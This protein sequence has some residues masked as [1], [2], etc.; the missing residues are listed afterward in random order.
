MS[1]FTSA[2][3]EVRNIGRTD[4]ECDL[5]SWK[6]GNHRLRNGYVGIRKIDTQNGQSFKV[7]CEIFSSNQNYPLFKCNVFNDS[8]ELLA[9][10]TR[11][12]I[13]SAVH[14]CLK[15]MHLVTKKRW[16]GTQFF[17]LTTSDYHAKLLEVEASNNNID[18]TTETVPQKDFSTENI[19][20]TNGSKTY[21]WIN[22]V[23]YGKVG[24]FRYKDIPLNV[25]YVSHREVTCTSGKVLVSCKIELDSCD[26]RR[27][28]YI[29]SSENQSYQHSQISVA[30]NSYLKQINCVGKKHWSGYDFFGITRKEVKITLNKMVNDASSNH[31]DIPSSS[32][33]LK[34]KSSQQP[35]VLNVVSNILNR[36]AGPTSNLS[37]KSYK[38]S[39]NK[40]IHSVVDS[41]SFGDVRSKYNVALINTV[42]GFT[43]S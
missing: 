28:S 6:A 39:R 38:D 24:N 20:L 15:E 4:N 21:G 32:K 18:T 34:P 17:G 19:E 43:Q 12:K 30:V 11:P 10:I 42:S 3:L 9:S 41:A 5:S 40:A 27:L 37:K 33:Q 1:S 25:G 36:N 31:D 22:V 16:A 35:E 23:Q 26:S 8:D 7:F 13:S 2:F 29:C 14:S